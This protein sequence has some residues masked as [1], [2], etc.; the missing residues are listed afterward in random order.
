MNRVKVR[1]SLTLRDRGRWLITT[2][3]HQ[4]SVDLRTGLVEERDPNGYIIPVL[5]DSSLQ[6]ERIDWLQLGRPSKLWLVDP[7][8][9]ST[10]VE[11]TGQVISIVSEPTS[12]SALR[13]QRLDLDALGAAYPTEA[14]WELLG[15]GSAELR[16]M[17]ADLR[18]LQVV[19]AKG[20]KA[21]PV[22]QVRA[23]GTLLPGLPDVLC[24][25]ADGADDPWTWWIWLTSRPQ[26]AD[27]RAVWELLADGDTDTV[28]RAAGRAA[29][30]WRQ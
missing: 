30:A 9:R 28:V 22:F 24:E 14:M 27:G 17:V 15:V 29:W 7:Q 6:L 20:E 19:G 8:N 4:F 5:D 10:S 25:L 23:D 2:T 18:A 3:D 1:T 26:Y 21:F 12:R 16:A 11:T 13:R